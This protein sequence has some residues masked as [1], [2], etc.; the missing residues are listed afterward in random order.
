MP[1]SA[2]EEA[3]AQK[4]LTT[5][6]SEKYKSWNYLFQQPFDISQVPGYAE[7]VGKPLD[8]E[9]VQASLTA[10]TYNT[11]TE[12]WNDVTGTF[13]NAVKYHTGRPTKWIAKMAKEM[14]KI[15]NKERKALDPMSFKKG[16]GGNGSGGNVQSLKIKLG[17]KKS[18]GKQ[19][20]TAAAVAQLPGASGSG[21]A[22]GT[23]S[24][25]SGAGTKTTP[26]SGK[27]KISLKLK[28]PTATA[29][30]T[31]A[32]APAA[33]A[34]GKPKISL[35]LKLPTAAAASTAAAISAA[36][37]GA[38]TAAAAPSSVAV[39]KVA[40]KISLK[41][42]LPTAAASGTAASK[43]SK[44]L[45]VKVKPTQPKLKLKL[46]LSLG[47]K[48]AKAAAV[49]AAG[50]GPPAMDSKP[51]TV[52]PPTAAATAATTATTAP[53]QLQPPPTAL[54]AAS[55]TAASSAAA[56]TKIQIK[57]A[58]GRGK[59]LPKMVAA[60][61]TAAT[62]KKKTATKKKKAA[63]STS[64]ATT[65]SATPAAASTAAATA[66]TTTAN[67]SSGGSSSN[68]NTKASAAMP[69]A[70]KQQCSKIIAGLRRRQQK[71]IA[72][73]A[74]PVADKAILPDYKAKI[75]H[76]MDLNTLQLRLE[77][78]LY[79][80]TTT[81]CRDI[82]RI[83]ANC[84]RYN[85]SIKDSL[86]P[87]A[88]QVLQTAEQLMMQ[89]VGRP[90]A[91]AANAATGQQGQQQSYPPLL[92]CWKLCIEILDTLYNL[93]NPADGQPVAL[94]FL[95]PVSYY[96]GGQFPT[97]YLQKVSKPMDF[98][99]VTA[100]LLEGRYQTVDAF[101]AD[102][103]L[104]I[105]NCLKYYESRD[106]G[107]LYTEQATRLRECLVRPLDQVVRYAKSIKGISDRAK[108]IQPL[109]RP[110]GGLLMECLQD[111]RALTY[112]DKATK[113]TE[114]AMGPFE[115]PV[116]LAAF[117]DYTQYVQ[118]PIDLQAVERKA[119]GGLYESPEDFEYDVNLIF[120]NCETYN[121]R[122][123][124]DHLVAMAKY[125]ARQFRRLFYARVR[126]FEDPSS[127]PPPKVERAESTTQQP[128]PDR[129]GAGTPSPPGKKIKIEAGGVSKGK[130]APRISLTAAQVSSAAAN[131]APISGA[132]SP[133]NVPTRKPV[134]QPLPKA[135]QP[136]PLHIAIARVKEAFPLR[137]AVKSLQSWEADCA[138][139]FKELMRHPWISAA[140]PKFIFH[141]PVPVL[142]PELSEA[143]AAKIRKQMDLTTVECTLLAGNRYA[144]PEDFVSDVALVFANAV[145][146]NK[147]GRDVGDPLSCA[148]Y[149][150]SVHL[151][152][153]AKWLSLELLADHVVDNDQVDEA[154]AD[155][156]PPF[157]WKLGTGNRKKAR[158]EMEA[159]V[160]KEP[161]EKSLEGDRWTWHEA[162]GEKLLKAL[163]HQSDLRYMTFFIQPN[164]PA[165]YT[166]FISKPMDWE[167]VQ[168][169]LKKRQYDK[170]GDIIDDLR[171]IFSN[172]LKYNAR[173]K[174]TDTV[175]GRAY[176]SA[177]YMSA[178]LEASINK[179]MFSAGDRLERERIDHANAE[180]EIEAAERA[181]EA[182]IRAAWKKEP[183]KPGAAPTPNRNDA[184]QQKIRLVRRAQRRETA[185]FE[186]P[187][188]DEEDDGQHERSYFEVIKFQKAM[189]E[190]QRQELSKMRQASIA[191]GAGV[192]GR[193]LQ[194]DL[195]QAWVKK[196]SE[197][198]KVSVDQPPAPPAGDGSKNEA[199][200]GQEHGP[201]VASSVLGE[202]E[203]E[204][205]GPL[206]VKLIAPKAKA[207]KRKR[208]LLS[209]D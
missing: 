123:N 71:H 9:T 187:F 128:A 47:N 78:D 91:A 63:V 184:M 110:P 11:F 113:I 87:V 62:K 32:A 79:K 102:C 180:R 150:A 61:T 14:L 48:K 7:I 97:D 200:Q 3:L 54:A 182:A 76:A 70:M 149:D 93:V 112:T 130:I 31:A 69:P 94:Y 1:L 42:K 202:L 179:L 106:D 52:K 105:T 35:K 33:A 166:A 161:I 6:R 99:T 206:Q 119:K 19:L 16:S 23:S 183:D 121:A 30:S 127:V 96:C 153:Y 66:T 159:L 185:D 197:K 104:V 142:F 169:T 90:S 192:F 133:N 168:R 117:S 64:S 208:P 118:E 85:T 57:A 43:P 162:E 55:T 188:F 39:P 92:F 81:F 77:K 65:A 167:K 190:K 41:L 158:E 194:R 75:P 27:P 114:P 107:R 8:L 155:G 25:S 34:S 12:Y 53:P 17:K 58:P 174:G 157:S 2:T 196:E 126:A 181:E 115:K 103:K 29:A 73:F 59:E 151:L 67:S 198:T 82:R 209:L 56:T 51:N 89:Y 88:V 122:R 193:L 116:S 74:Q 172:A 83:F 156:L 24:T 21:S 165:D 132:R 147:D 138:R 148:Y 26:A 204:G 84:L 171:L 44:D 13:H 207:K 18:E 20:P 175:S 129:S 40:P 108:T 145:R 144:G 137:R 125:G 143:Y 191:V 195:A 100:E 124:G 186:I 163:R 160:L 37:A 80:D 135:N 134:S 205:R 170:F 201:V 36:A 68:N 4:L 72:W 38:T 15:A 178:K 10:L 22:V 120:R 189:F 154:T 139:Y 146:F 140:R 98:G 86:R 199:N 152:R 173:L 95:H 176:E 203:R 28:L 49:A 111:L 50:A 136:V 46:K 101:C 109:P 45:P 141:V 164:Y 131:A 177:K 5:I 60:S